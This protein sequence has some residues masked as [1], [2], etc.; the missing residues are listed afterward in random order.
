MSTESDALAQIHAISASAL[1]LPAADSA[2]GGAPVAGGLP[3]VTTKPDAFA[4]LGSSNQDPK[5]IQV[6]P[7]QVV[8]VDFTAGEA[9]RVLR[10]FGHPGAFFKHS[11]WAIFDSGGGRVM[12][13]DNVTAV[14]TLGT[15]VDAA[16]LAHLSAGATYRLGVTTD[17]AGE[18]A[19]QLQ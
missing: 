13:A 11:S 19:I 2:P 6:V 5:T 17:G 1:G 4:D 8:G 10:W 9:G 3:S 16:T 7:N 12:G 18:L 15:A 14:G